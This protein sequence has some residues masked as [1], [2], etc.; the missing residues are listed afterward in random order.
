MNR[1]WTTSP[2]GVETIN[3]TWE[4]VKLPQWQICRRTFHS[5]VFEAMLLT[6]ADS[7]VAELGL[8]FGAS[9]RFSYVIGWL[10]DTDT[11]TISATAGRWTQ[12]PWCPLV[13]SSIH[14]IIVEKVILTLSTDYIMTKGPLYYS[15]NISAACG[16]KYLGKPQSCCRVCSL[17]KSRYTS[18][19]FQMT[20]SYVY[21]SAG[22]HRS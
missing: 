6:R 20:C 21:G 4:P 9:A 14:F 22:P 17:S 15:R 1:L 18:R 5:C 19:C 10:A 12:T 16:Y 13:P 7:N 3:D 2:S 8:F 11:I